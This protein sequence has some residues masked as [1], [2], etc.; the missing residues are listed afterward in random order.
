MFMTCT[1]TLSST[2]NTLGWTGG[3]FAATLDSQVKP[4]WGASPHE[5]KIF[6]FSWKAWYDI[7]R[8]QK[9]PDGN[10]CNGFKLCPDSNEIEY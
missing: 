5:C 4:A 6:F 8:A 7:G 1:N 10:K 3:G 2:G 9:E